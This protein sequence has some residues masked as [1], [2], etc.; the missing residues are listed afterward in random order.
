[1]VTIIGLGPVG[2][3]L[4]SLLGDSGIEVMVLEA[5]QQL[6]GI[7]RA[8]AL[9]GESL[10]ILRSAGITKSSM[11]EMQ[12]HQGL[13]FF[14]GEGECYLKTAIKGSPSYPSSLLMYQPHL[15]T[16]LE[17]RLKEYPHVKV[18]WGHEFLAHEQTE[19]RLGVTVQ[20]KDSEGNKYTFFTEYLIGCDGANSAVRKSMDVTMRRLWNGQGSILKADAWVP[21][22]Q[23]PPIVA[24]EKH[25]HPAIP[26]VQ[27]Q[28][29]K[30]NGFIQQR[31][32]FQL[33]YYKDKSQHDDSIPQV[34]RY[35]R[36]I[37]YTAE[38]L[39]GIRWDH[40]A[41]YNYQSAIARQWKKG[42]VLLAGDAAHLTPPYIGQGLNAGMKDAFNLYWK[43]IEAHQSKYKIRKSTALETYQAERETQVL[44][45][46]RV[47]IGVG[48]L[49]KTN[50]H[51]TVSKI[52]KALRLQQTSLIVPPLGL[53]KKGGY[54]GTGRS[55]AKLF[56]PA[57]LYMD[58]HAVDLDIFLGKKWGYFSLHSIPPKVQEYCQQNGIQHCHLTPETDLTQ[59]LTNWMKMNRRKTVLVRPDRYVYGSLAVPH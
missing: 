21:I 4:A 51:K 11:P 39:E 28:G 34:M 31:W 14:D 15:D 56:P 37:G 47:A 36:D 26:W 50:L 9:D 44:I 18:L 2:M 46:T 48:W 40:I 41:V 16:A 7:P 38:Q 30:Q 12:P 1:M 43:I 57:K 29:I 6:P 52:S 25:S 42:N 23:L 19:N 53:G 33:P 58:Q 3:L 59:A 20:A 13:H 35:L 55:V 49:F 5:R 32:E 27:M 45:S 10:R 8:I 22:G 24:V 17:Q 54:W